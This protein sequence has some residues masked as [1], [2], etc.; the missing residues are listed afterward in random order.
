MH[1][2]VRS[3]IGISDI[4]DYLRIALYWGLPLGVA[5]TAWLFRRHSR[6]V[7]A[8]GEGLLGAGTFDSRHPEAELRERGHPGQQR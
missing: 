2:D 6:R 3:V 7:R 5:F 8:L 1:F 4:Y